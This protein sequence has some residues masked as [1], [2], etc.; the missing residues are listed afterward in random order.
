MQTPEEMN[1]I[2]TWLKPALYAAFAALGGVLGH[3]MRA[4]DKN[5]RIVVIRA[6]IE[7]VAAG[8]VGLMVMLACQAL[9][10]NEQWTGVCVGVCGWLGA[11]A[12]IRLLESVVY[13]KLGLRRST[14]PLA[15]P[16]TEE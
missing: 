5:E 12:T 4:Y 8:F 10:L 15:L 13:K 9:T 6:S 2:S 3:I 11:T 1:T 16:T 7:G 14:D